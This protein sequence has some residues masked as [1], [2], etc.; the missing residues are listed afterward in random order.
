MKIQRVL[1]PEVVLDVRGPKDARSVYKTLLSEIV[2]LPGGR[3]RYPA[4]WERKVPGV[5]GSSAL[6]S[7]FI[8]KEYEQRRPRNY[9]IPQNFGRALS[10]VDKNIP[11]RV[12]PEKF[13]A[14]F[15]LGENTISDEEGEVDCAYVK[16]D[17]S[18]SVPGERDISVFYLNKLW[19]TTTKLRMRLEEKSITS[20]VEA[21]KV[22]DYVPEEVGG[23][24]VSVR[25]NAVK[26]SSVPLRSAVFRLFINAVVYLHTQDPEL[27]SLSPLPLLSKTRRAQEIER[28]PDVL[29]L[30]SIPLTLLNFQFNQ[31]RQ[32]SVGS[33]PVRGHLRWQ[34][35]GPAFSQVKLIWIDEHERHFNQE[36]A[37]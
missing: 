10:L 31:P 9:F 26:G 13:F 12:L 15:Q 22:V 33:A 28:S 24:T 37:V 27:L 25:E 2:L 3:A 19:Q 16:I 4:E 18:V 23:K 17:P 11:T 36:G 7:F 5:R 29:N 20:L 6:D 1:H 32:Y 8:L 35:F 34:P 14:F 21:A 30:C